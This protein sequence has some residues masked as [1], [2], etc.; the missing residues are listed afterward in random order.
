MQREGRKLLTMGKRLRPQKK[1]VKNYRPKHKNLGGG[2]KILG[3]P[4][5]ADTLATPLSKGCKLE[6]SSAF[7]GWPDETLYIIKLKVITDVFAC[8]ENFA[9]WLYL[10]STRLA[11]IFVDK[12]KTQ[13]ITKYCN[14]RRIEINFLY[15]RLVF[16]IVVHCTLSITN[17]LSCKFLALSTLYPWEKVVWSMFIYKLLKDKVKCKNI[18][19]TLECSLIATMTTDFYSM[20]L[21]SNKLELFISRVIN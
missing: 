8:N 14:Y 19:L 5:A 20:Y 4:R 10:H 18:R 2:R 11:Y 3:P 15:N 7:P 1:V 17:I 13:E 6:L 9:L 21:L 12:R 16:D